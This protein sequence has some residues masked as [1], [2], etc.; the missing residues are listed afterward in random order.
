M[1]NKTFLLIKK[2]KLFSSLFE[3]FLIKKYEKPNKIKE[4]LLKNNYIK[5]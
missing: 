2:N 3:D 5:I 1:T 4:N